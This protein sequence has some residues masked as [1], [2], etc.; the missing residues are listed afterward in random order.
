MNLEQTTRDDIQRDGLHQAQPLASARPEAEQR[1]KEY[2]AHLDRLALDEDY[3]EECR[4]KE[5][6]YQA[7][8][9]KHNI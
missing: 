7:T 4:I 3:A 8:M 2:K 5:L 1:A 9:N 6:E